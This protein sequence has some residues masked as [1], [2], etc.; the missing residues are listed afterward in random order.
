MAGSRK[1]PQEEQSRHDEAVR[2]SAAQYKARGYK[3]QADIEGFPQPNLLGG[4]R[5]DLVAEKGRKKVVVEFETPSTLAADKLQ[6]R[7]LR[8]AAQKMGAE[9]RVR[10]A[11]RK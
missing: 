8:R 9:F 6:H 1:R 11:G 2:R 7:A 10:V 3:V 4:R 5:P